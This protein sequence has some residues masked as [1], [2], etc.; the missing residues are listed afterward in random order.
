MKILAIA[1]N[2][3]PATSI[4]EA[5]AGRHHRIDYHEIA[6]AFAGQYIDYSSTPQHRLLRRLEEPLRLD[7]Q[8]AIH[9]ARL[10][11]RQKIDVVISLSERVGIPL[12]MM[13]DRRVRHIVFMHHAMSPIKIALMRALKVAS[14]ITTFITISPA[15]SAGLRQ[16][17]NIAE[18]QIATMLTPVDLAFWQPPTTPPAADEPDH[19][20]SL[21]LSY[22]DYPTLVRAMHELPHVRGH[23]RAGSTWVAHRAGYERESIPANIE[24]KPY[25]HP[26]D[27]REIIARSRFVVV[28]IR[29][30][31]QWSAGC[32][33]VQ[34]AQAMGKAVITTDMPGLRSYMRAGETGILTAC[35]DVA[36]LQRAINF[37]WQ[38]PN[39]AEQMGYHGRR[40]VQQ[41]ASIDTWLKQLGYLLQ[42][43]VP[44]GRTLKPLIQ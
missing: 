6:R 44:I 43:P 40:F 27:L 13:L 42:P 19:F 7:I 33:S 14:H 23:I 11:H 17:L 21:G 22:R 39:V 2:E 20:L 41:T 25:V 28:P 12:S 10:V 38:N 29:D 3:T 26:A 15:E 30:T 24:L 8:Q 1:T 5:E 32:T 35:G 37:L 34:L 4:A 36:G 16:L 9:A 31:T 18:G